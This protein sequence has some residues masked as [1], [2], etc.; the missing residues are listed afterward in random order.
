M[1]KWH[2]TPD[3]DALISDYERRCPVTDAY[4]RAASEEQRIEI[5]R[6][7]KGDCENCK[8]YAYC[9]VGTLIDAAVLGYGS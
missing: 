1:G 6:R 8:R 5:A 2:Y 7:N 4:G 3:E 9:F